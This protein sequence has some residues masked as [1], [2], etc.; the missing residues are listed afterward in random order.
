M[1]F[2][3]DC[4]FVIDL[5]QIRMIYGLIDLAKALLKTLQTYFRSYNHSH[6]QKPLPQSFRQVDCT[7]LNNHKKLC[8][9]KTL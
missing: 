7:D 9:S 3:L 6:D 4:I 2:I 8:Q 1:S 5:S